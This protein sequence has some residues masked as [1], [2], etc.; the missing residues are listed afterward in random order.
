MFKY[1]KSVVSLDQIQNPKRILHIDMLY[2]TTD[3]K[4]KTINSKMKEKLKSHSWYIFIPLLTP[5]TMLTKIKIMKTYYLTSYN[6]MKP[7]KKHK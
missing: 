2:A 1:A 5:L 7:R 4:I 3:N 6:K